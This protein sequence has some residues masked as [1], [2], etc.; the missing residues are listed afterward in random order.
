VFVV[1]LEHHLL[2]GTGPDQIAW[3]PYPWEGWTPG[4]AA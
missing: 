4:M 2:V 3:H 1:K